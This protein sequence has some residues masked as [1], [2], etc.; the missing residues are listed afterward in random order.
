MIIDLHFSSDNSTQNESK[1]QTSQCCL[2]MQF[3]GMCVV[4]MYDTSKIYSVIT[5]LAFKVLKA[6]PQRIRLHPKDK[7][8]TIQYTCTI[9][10]PQKRKS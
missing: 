5:I 8:M 7:R 2:C 10:N 6:R 9:I 1:T 4:Y 3:T